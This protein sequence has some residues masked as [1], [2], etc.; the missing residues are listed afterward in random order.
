[1]EGNRYWDM[2]RHGRPLSVRHPR[3]PQGNR[4]AQFAAYAALSGFGDVIDEAGRMTLQ[5]IEMSESQEEMLDERLNLLYDRLRELPEIKVQF[6]VKDAKKEGG[7]VVTL[8]GR[9]Q[10]IQEEKLFLIGEKTIPIKDITNLAG[11]IFEGLE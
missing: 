4:A 3:M 6:F 7:K 11:A 5:R 9:A 2:M 8:W 10:K 1:M